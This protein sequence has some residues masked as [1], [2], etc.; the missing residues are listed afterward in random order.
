MSDVTS[1]HRSTLELWGG[2]RLTLKHSLHT[3]KFHDLKV[4][5]YTFKHCYRGIQL[6]AVR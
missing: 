6:A 4:H 1:G 2:H 3:L 5:M